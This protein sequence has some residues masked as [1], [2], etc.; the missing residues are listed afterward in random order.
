MAKANHAPS[1]SLTF[2]VC[3]VSG[4]DEIAVYSDADDH[5]QADILSADGPPPVAK[6]GPRDQCHK[7]GDEQDETLSARPR[8]DVER[9]DGC[10]DNTG[11]PA[12][13]LKS[14]NESFVHFPE[15]AP[16]AACGVHASA[17]ARPVRPRQRCCAAF[18]QVPDCA[19][20]EPWP[21]DFSG[22]VSM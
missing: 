15:L 10:G 16:T 2:G 9:D 21:R 19:R 7:A 11:D 4:R 17:P 8:A 1:L 18:G 5:E 22:R 14:E 6:E 20:G 13:P 12:V 3:V